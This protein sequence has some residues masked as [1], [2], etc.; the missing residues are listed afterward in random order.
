MGGSGGWLA[1]DQGKLSGLENRV[2]D[3]VLALGR[4]RE[5]ELTVLGYTREELLWH[6]TYGREHPEDHHDGHHEQDAAEHQKR[7]DQYLR[8]AERIVG[9]SDSYTT[10][11]KTRELW[12]RFARD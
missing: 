5:L 7:R 3:N 6:A 9:D 1:R 8:T 2:F 4:V 10:S 12:R 11:D